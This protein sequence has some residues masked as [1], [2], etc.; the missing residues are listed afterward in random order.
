MT[1]CGRGSNVP[2]INTSGLAKNV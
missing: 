1:L 2:A